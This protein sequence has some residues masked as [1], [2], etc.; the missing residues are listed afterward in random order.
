M[1]LSNT[2][3]V[4]R[5]V[6]VANSTSAGVALVTAPSAGQN[7]VLV[8]LINADGSNIATLKD[9][10][11]SAVDTL[12]A[13]VTVST[14]ISL[15]APILVASKKVVAGSLGA[16]PPGGVPANNITV[17][18]EPL[19]KALV[20]GD[21]ITFAGGGVFTLDN[22]YAAGVT[23]IVGDLTVLGNLNA[24]EV[25]YTTPKVWITG[26]TKFTATY[27]LGYGV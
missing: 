26:S 25:G 14:A 17:T 5:T 1:I 27:M 21:V 23:S 9:K 8:D 11:G 16:D 20:A 18:V 12:L 22:G 2:L 6:N 15:T 13:Q 10:H 19:E 4:P 3:S 24:D 7:F